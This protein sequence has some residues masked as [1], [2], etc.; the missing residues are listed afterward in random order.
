MIAALLL[1]LA[2]AVLR[3][4]LRVVHQLL[5]LAHQLRQ[6]VQHLAQGP[7]LHLALLRHAG[8]QVAQNVLKLGEHLFGGLIG[9]ALGELL[10]HVQH[11]LQVLRAHHAALLHLLLVLV[12]LALGHP[13]LRFLHHGLHVAV[14]C[15]A[16]LLGQFG[17]A[18]GAG[19]VAQCA[20]ECL[21][22]RI[23]L[24]LGIAGHAVLDVDGD[25]PQHADH[26]VNA[27]LVFRRPEA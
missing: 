20:L 11:L 15:L 10:D 27:G 3:Y 14:Q 18:L 5:L 24:C 8:L 2:H 7:V 6:L 21:A 25:L 17:D 12:H 23:E 9:A 4:A 16:Q 1:L 26:A 22:G 13:L 19:A